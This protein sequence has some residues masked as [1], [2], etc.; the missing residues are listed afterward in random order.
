[1]SE[2]KLYLT[3]NSTVIALHPDKDAPDNYI[4]IGTVDIDLSD[5]ADLIDWCQMCVDA[6]AIQLTQKFNSNFKKKTILPS[7]IN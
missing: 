6:S 7:D 5:L 4:Y 1:M 3:D 2:F